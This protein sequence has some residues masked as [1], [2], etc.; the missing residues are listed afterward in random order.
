MDTHRLHTS[1]L[2]LLL[3]VIDAAMVTEAKLVP[4][5]YR[6]TCPRAERIVTDVVSQK[7]LSHPTTAAGVL[8]VFFHDCFVSGCDASVLVSPTA[9]A[10][11]ERDAA[12]SQSLPGDAFEAVARAK[13][14]LEL[15]CP[16]VVSCADVLAIAARDLVTMT[17]GPFYPLRL[18]RKDALASSSAA[19]DAE[20]PL[21]NSTVP[22]LVAMF[23]AKGFTVQELVALSGA[24][25]LGFAHCAEFAD[26]IFRRG[27][28]GGGA[29]P[30]PHDPAM[31]PAY[32]KGLHDA[33]RN[34]QRDPTI[35][36]FN[37]VMTPG[38]FDNMYFVNLQRGLGLLSTD[39]E[40]WTDPR[41][42]PFVQRYA[43]NQTAFFAD[44]ARAIVKLG[45]MGVKTGRDGEVRRRC[46]M[47]NGNPVPGG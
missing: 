27:N 40:L 7:Q 31:N 38:K 12:Q 15:A 5:Y 23:A 17:G 37:D 11:S 24:H 36:V 26:R 33:C 42:R 18:G 25:T 29:A 4:N 28:K 34:Y 3:L 6:K 43:A 10:R 46:D 19:P 35:A 16:G 21:A 8:R 39:Q 9:F 32:A 20:L 45:V 22:R 14:A 44:F 30:A 1:A 13:T 47:F 41:T 2:F